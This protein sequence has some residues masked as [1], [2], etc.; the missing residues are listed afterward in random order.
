[1]LKKLKKK[2]KQGFS[3]D[4]LGASQQC[5]L[6]GIAIYNNINKINKMHFLITKAAFLYLLLKEKVLRINGTSVFPIGLL[7]WNHAWVYNRAF[8]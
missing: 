4:I 2:T 1:M 6:C 8:H 7:Y 3:K 5:N